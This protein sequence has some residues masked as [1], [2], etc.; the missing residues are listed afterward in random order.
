[1]HARL[2]VCSL[3]IITS[4]AGCG[5]VKD[6]PPDDD[7]TVEVAPIVR[8]R[9]G[10]TAIVDVSVS[11]GRFEGAIEVSA[12][13]LPSGVSAAPV[14]IGA[15]ATAASLIVRAEAGAAQVGPLQFT[16]RVAVDAP[17]EVPLRLYVAGASGAPDTSFS[18]DGITTV[19]SDVAGSE[20]DGRDVLI[21]DAGRIVVAGVVQNIT[22]NQGVMYRLTAQGVNDVTFGTGG[23]LKPAFESVEG[24]V[25]RPDGGYFAVTYSGGTRVQQLDD[26]GAPVGAAIAS[27]AST[28]GFNILALPDGF[29][30]SGGSV[31]EKYTYD[32]APAEF[33]TGGKVSFATVSGPAVDSR[34]R[35]VAAAGFRL[36]RLQPNGDADLTFAI[37]FP[38]P[39][40]ADLP[41]GRS[42]VLAPDD[43]GW[44]C[45]SMRIG[46]TIYD[47]VPI[48][49]RFRA[50][51]TIDT[52]F[53]NGG[54]RPLLGDG[55]GTCN[56]AVRLPDGRLLLSATRILETQQ[57]QNELWLVHADGS[58]DT[59]FGTGG[60]VIVPNGRLSAV[61]VDEGGRAIAV[62]AQMGSRLYVTR[63]WL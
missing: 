13:G 4:I 10:A 5:E 32:G 56:R 38:L 14:Q 37:T 25:V 6:A 63:L 53:G 52:S 44:L 45:G 24:V 31:I 43:G 55:N 22:P 30:V 28:S 36:G 50:D 57:F 1:M 8:V 17:I 12:V 49:A 42:V 33:G 34:G 46:T 15:G 19:T 47:Q 23:R 41:A 26:A 60:A 7:P 2:L 58:L 11:R 40:G 16:L 39:P 29:L 48:L 62:G 35:I 9:Q 20:D 54:I 3:V 18:G 59:T 51:G 61:T 21:D 27:S